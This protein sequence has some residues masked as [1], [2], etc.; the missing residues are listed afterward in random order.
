[1]RSPQ[2]TPNDPRIAEAN[3]E[4]ILN[5]RVERERELEYRYAVMRVDLAGVPWEVAR[6]RSA[7]A[8]LEAAESYPRSRTCLTFAYDT[9]DP[10]TG[11]LQ[12]DHP[13]VVREWDDEA[14]R[15]GFDDL[16]YDIRFVDPGDV[17]PDDHDRVFGE[18]DLP[19]TT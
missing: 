7:R 16:G 19:W 15:H 13:A 9:D 8:A 10:E 12:S 11:Q 5:R 2:A 6:S 18:G 3:A 14:A 1:M 4:R 17:H